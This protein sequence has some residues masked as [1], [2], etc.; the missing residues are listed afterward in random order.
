MQ[1]KWPFCLCHIS[2]YL[3]IGWG[4]RGLFLKGAKLNS[5]VSCVGRVPYTIH[6]KLHELTSWSLRGDSP[7]SAELIGLFGALRVCLL[8]GIKHTLQ[9]NAIKIRFF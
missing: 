3:T 4:V 5:E 8:K 1:E 2:G 6:T 9:D 7:C